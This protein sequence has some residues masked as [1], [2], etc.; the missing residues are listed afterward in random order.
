MYA[1]IKA[2]RNNKHV[3]ELVKA[4]CKT[5]KVLRSSQVYIS[6]KKLAYKNINKDTEEMPQSWSTAFP[7][8]QE[9][10]RQGTN[11]NKT[12]A[13]YEIADAQWKKKCNRVTALERTVG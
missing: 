1:V 10:E 12:N 4:C 5:A 13:T 2:T 8:H 6:I 9:Q 11:N 3:E 7:R